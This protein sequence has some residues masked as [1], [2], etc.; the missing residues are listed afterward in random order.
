M[1]KE[2]TDGN[3]TGMAAMNEPVFKQLGLEHDGF[4]N[5]DCCFHLPFVW[6]LH[7]AR[8]PM[9]RY[10][11]N[12]KGNSPC[13]QEYDWDQGEWFLLYV[14][15]ITGG[16]LFSKTHHLQEKLGK[17]QVQIS[18]CVLVPNMLP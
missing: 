10:S 4:N 12:S 9:K 11:T 15:T 18:G 1:V 2:G 3:R 17:S 13:L 5:L 16:S 7:A 8:N 6:Q 14:P